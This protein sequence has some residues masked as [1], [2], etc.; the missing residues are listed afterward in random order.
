MSQALPTF[1]V[2]QLAR[3][4]DLIQTKRLIVSLQAQG[5]VHLVVDRSLTDLARLIYPLVTVHGLAAHGTH[6][7]LRLADLSA[8]MGPVAE[9]SFDRVYNLNFSGLNFALSTLFTPGTVRGYF[10]NAGQRHIDSWPGHV[11]RWTKNRAQTGINLVDVWGLYA[12]T[13]VEPEHVNPAATG[14][15]NGLG[16]V[17][18]GQNARRSLPPHILAPFVQAAKARTGS[19]PITLFGAGNEGRA[20]R[21]LTAL[22]PA[23]MRGQVRNLVGKTDWNALIQEVSSL[24]LLLTPDTGTMHLAASLGVPVLAFFLSSAWCHETGPYGR[25]HEILQATLPCAPCLETAPC[26][27]ALACQKFFTDRAVLRYISG[28]T[29]GPLPNGFAVMSSGFDS[30]GLVFSATAG[31]DPLATERRNFR[32]FAASLAGV[33]RQ[34]NSSFPG[35]TAHLDIYE[36]DWILPQTL[37]GR[38]H[39]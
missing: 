34:E 7:A 25:G 33:T 19:G 5:A 38:A 1:L 3:F 9:I 37:R 24:D 39:E 15:G 28:N 36:R 21:E 11:M 18:A 26:P 8:E 32:A 31:H 23:S 4:G 6:G 17:M 35:K 27:H 14:Q 12:D 29:S 30:L 2:I 20:A 16:V 13:P 22:L 10:Q